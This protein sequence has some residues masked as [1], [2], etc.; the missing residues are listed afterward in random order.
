MV[1]NCMVSPAI[2]KS[3]RLILRALLGIDHARLE[4]EDGVGHVDVEI[5]FFL[6][7][8]GDHFE[9]GEMDVVFID[10][11]SRW[12]LRNARADGL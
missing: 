3:V 6:L 9:V 10:A 7:V 11:G 4:I 12:R 8:E 2:S 1:L 5:G